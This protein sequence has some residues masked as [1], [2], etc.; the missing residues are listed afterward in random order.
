MNDLI[1]PA[2]Y[3]ASPRCE[4]GHA[5]P[6]PVAAAS[7]PRRRPGLRDRRFPRS[8]A[9]NASTEGRRSGCLDAPGPTAPSGGQYNSRPLVA[10]GAGLGAFAVVRPRQTYED[11]IGLDR[12]AA[13]LGADMP[14]GSR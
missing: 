14:V 11:L 9:R 5:C 10:R 6:P 13:W 1:R 7:W 4:A 2:M 8:W 12:L 3:D